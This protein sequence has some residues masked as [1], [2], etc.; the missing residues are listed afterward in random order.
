MSSPVTDPNAWRT[1]TPGSAGWAHRARGDPNKYFVVSADTHANE[2]RPCGASGS[3]RS[4]RP[5]PRVEVDANGG[6]GA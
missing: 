1:A 2:P 3:T 6:A 4:T 5:L